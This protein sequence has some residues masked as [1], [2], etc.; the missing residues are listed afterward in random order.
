MLLSGS[1]RGWLTLYI[2]YDEAANTNSQAGSGSKD[3]EIG[4]WRREE[5]S[6]SKKKS[7]WKKT[8]V[9]EQGSSTNSSNGV[10]V[11]RQQH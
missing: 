3:H 5:A 10:D 8:A 1:C 4:S 9:N 6:R 11:E 7:W 2:G